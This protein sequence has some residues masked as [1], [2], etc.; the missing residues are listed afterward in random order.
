MCLERQGDR[1]QCKQVVQ[2][3]KVDM[4]PQENLSKAG[5]WALLASVGLLGEGDG[6]EACRWVPAMTAKRH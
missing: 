5:S 6:E 3:T 1:A 4:V 2:G